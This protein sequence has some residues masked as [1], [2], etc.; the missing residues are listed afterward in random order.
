MGTQLNGLSE[1]AAFGDDSQMD[2]NFPIVRLTD[3]SGNVF[4]ART[5]NWSSTGVMT[6][7]QTVS[8]EFRVSEFLPP[9]SYSLAVVANGI[10]SDSVSFSGPIYVNFN[11]TGLLQF[12]TYVFPFAT[13]A[14]GVGAVPVGGTIVLEGPGTSAETMK[15]SKAM[16][17][18]AIAGASTIGR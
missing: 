18:T 6:G 13:L 1:G 15:L 10:S 11:Y 5:F 4:Y 7:N 16:R 12:G 9:G 3:A 8:T 14:Q 17:L 2:S